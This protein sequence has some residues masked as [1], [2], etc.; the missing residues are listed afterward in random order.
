M[1]NVQRSLMLGML[2]LGLVGEV[3]AA[4]PA[5]AGV[6]M[7]ASGSAAGSGSGPGV[8]GESVATS[9][10][11]GSA[12]APA[13][14]APAPATTTSTA[15]PTSST[16]TTSAEPAERPIRRFRPE[17][18]MVELGVFGGITV[19]SKT[20]DLYDPATAM[21]REP[22]R[23]PTPDF[24]ARVAYFPLSFFGLEAEFSALPA[25]YEPA[26]DKAF[27]YGFRGHGILQLPMF[28]VAP[29]LLGG[30]GLMGVSSSSAVAGKDIDPVGHYGVGVKYS[31]IRVLALRLDVRHL[32]AAQRAQQVDGT[33]HLQVLLGLSLTLNRAKP[34][35][36]SKLPE[37][38]VDPDRDRDGFLN[39]V[40]RCPDERGIAPD[41]C[42][43]KD[44]DGD[45]FMDSVDKC[46][47]VV[48]VAPDGCPPKDRDR[49][50]FLDEVDKCP[51]EPGVAPDGCPLRDTD[52][53]GIL[54]PDDKCVNDP[55]TRNGYEDA[56]GCPDE[57]P[58]AVA[59]F[60]GVIRG[61]YFDFGKDSIRK[62]STR[63]LNEAATIFNE[64]PDVKV[65]IS[66]H[67]D[68]VGKVEYNR[69]L[70]RRRA[71]SVKTYLV[72]KGVKPERISTRGAGPD[73]PIADN[74][75][76]KGRAKNRRIEFKIMLE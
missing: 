26:G 61:I 66:G 54:D 14:A 2:G 46:P 56:D 70:S 10:A 28:R 21:P 60:T 9:G 4:E 27:V 11:A 52:G 31:Y 17:R 45:T 50:S 29:F 19:F 71:E 55:E 30:Y 22:L 57:L 72:G 41:G 3:S 25:K 18:N 73:E 48:G 74:A 15:T 63:T 43:D 12:D 68:N 33:S 76:A 24:G 20:H 58:K 34:K 44:S 64:Y 37:P 53:D 6:G 13:A 5:G 40:D 39:E 8:T 47:E 1:S 32:V 16:P 75:N 49:D 59:K 7:S 42:P 23:R 36:A 65:E 67:T 69:D 38:V 51:D 62:Q 35:P